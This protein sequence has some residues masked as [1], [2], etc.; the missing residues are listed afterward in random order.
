MRIYRSI[1]VTGMA[2]LLAASFLTGCQ[3][4]ETQS[5]WQATDSSLGVAS[6]LTIE[7]EGETYHVFTTYSTS[8]AEDL[9]TEHLGAA[10]PYG[11]VHKGES[12]DLKNDSYDVYWCRADEGLIM[13]AGLDTSKMLVY[14]CDKWEKGY[15]YLM[16]PESMDQQMNTPPSSAAAS[17][18]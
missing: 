2:I 1:L 16:I 3:K 4:K 12:A 10:S 15:A 17:A 13:A 5:V 6:T 7:W 18:G 11:Q 9:K 14:F 8:E